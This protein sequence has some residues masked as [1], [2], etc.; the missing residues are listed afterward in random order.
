MRSY[1]CKAFRR[2]AKSHLHCKYN[3]SVRMNMGMKLST[4]VYDIISMTTT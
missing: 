1:V 4:P 3:R 2:F